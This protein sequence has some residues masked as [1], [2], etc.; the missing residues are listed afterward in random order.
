MSFSIEKIAR[1]NVELLK[2]NAVDLE[3]LI[4]NLTSSVLIFLDTQNKG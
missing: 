2:Q 4:K 1:Y 3:R